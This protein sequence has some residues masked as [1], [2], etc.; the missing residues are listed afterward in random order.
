MEIVSI[1]KA[2][3]TAAC[4]V[5]AVHEYNMIILHLQIPG[6]TLTF[7]VLVPLGH[8]TFC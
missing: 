2:F 6:T 1:A 7:L 3:I 5:T 4:K 8:D